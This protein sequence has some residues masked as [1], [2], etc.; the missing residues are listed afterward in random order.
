M[1][2]QQLNKQK[3]DQKTSCDQLVHFLTTNDDISCTFL[4]ADPETSLLTEKK[5]KAK[6]NSALTVEELTTPLHADEAD[7][8][9]R[10]HKSG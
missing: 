5:K 2:Q 8:E 4:F 10:A 6:R 7:S 3:E 1:R 9:F